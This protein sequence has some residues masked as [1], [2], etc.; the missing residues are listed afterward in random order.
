V[1]IALLQSRVI[2]V[3]SPPSRFKYFPS[4]S[5]P[6]APLLPWSDRP[7]YPPPVDPSALYAHR[8]V[9]PLTADNIREH[10]KQAR[11]DGAA[12]WGGER[13]LGEGEMDGEAKN[14]FG[15]GAGRDQEAEDKLGE[16]ERIK[17]RRAKRYSS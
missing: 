6:S 2:A 17:E 13:G 14:G 16:W 15:S 11:F 3:I 12:G 8:L 7:P 1:P 9:L 4:T 10:A 5:P